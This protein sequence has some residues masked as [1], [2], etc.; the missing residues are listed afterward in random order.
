VVLRFQHHMSRL[1]S[2]L[3]LLLCAGTAWA[4]D[5]EKPRALE[6]KPTSDQIEFF[7]KKIRPA[8]VEHCYK[9]HSESAEKIKGGL[10]L[11]TR[12]GIRRGGDS[13]PAIVPGNLEESV[14]IQ[15]IRYRDKDFAMPPEK[16]GGKLPTEVIGDFEKWVQMGAPDPRDGAA[17]VVK[18]TDYE[19]AKKWWAFQPPKRAVPPAAKDAAWPRSDIDRFILAALE[20]KGLK[21][22]GDADK[23]TLLRR[24][25]FDLVGLPPSPEE[26]AAFVKDSSPGAL[27]KV[28]DSLLASSHFGE[29]WGR[30]WLDVARYAESAG[31][32]VNVAYPHAWRY[33]DYVIAAFNADKPFDQ[34]L[35]EQIAGDLLAEGDDRRRAE[36]LIA[37]GFLAIGPKSLNEQNPRQFALDVADEQIDA[38]SQAFLGMTVACARCHDHKFDP[39]S[40]REYTAL[41]GIFL[42]TDTRY[43]TPAGIQNRHPSEL[44]EL[45]TGGGAPTIPRSMSPGM[46]ERLENEAAELRKSRDA[47]IAERFGRR[48]AGENRGLRQLGEINRLGML[49]SQL[50]TFD[51]SGEPRALAMGAQDLP[52]QRAERG[53]GF[54]RSFGGPSVR[55]RIEQRLR[56]RPPE[57]M[58]VGD[59]PFFARGDADKPG[60]RVPRGFVQVLSPAGEPPRIDRRTSGRR[61]LA[62]WLAAEGNP[63]T[64]RVFVN[65]AWHWLFGRGLVE[66]VDNFGTTGAKPSNQALLD[67]L[68]V[69]FME[70]GWSIK[71]LVREIVLSRA[72][73][74]DSRFDAGSFSADPEN[75]L[76][77]RMSPRRLDAECVRD[78]MLQAGGTLEKSPPTGS[79]IALAGDGP[80]ERRRGRGTS[81]EAIIADRS[82]VRSVYLPIA[83]NV[84][85]DALEVFDFPEPSLVAGAR[86]TTN[87]PSQA[88]FLLNNPFV[89]AQAQKFAERVLA[90]YPGGP[91]GG[92]AAHL[93]QRVAYAFWLAFSRPPDP[94]EKQAAAA[95][96]A[97]FPSNWSK[98]D[99]SP[100]G[101]RD[102]GDVQ[103]AWTSFCRAL[104][105]SAEFRFLN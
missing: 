53:R 91:N 59:S 76:V 47:A 13:G 4:I 86:E 39:I 65:R 51:R 10:V 99:T 85:P 35:R 73:A 33:R 95:F 70:N 32:D 63:L 21:P 5:E 77:W 18:K 22:V 27:A 28:V 43:G 44:I 30:H 12:E 54:G 31:K 60:E 34:F 50:K 52:A 89:A 62:E 6:A 104:F 103:A 96:F 55:E 19:E 46:R 83:R 71:K 23:L 97:K 87:V 84:L 98:G 69:S 66:S 58:T 93:D 1:L 25:Y 100:S 105:A 80:I 101:I 8:L 75:A 45:P 29:R 9:C 36:M 14:L 26:A 7:E 79:V 20:E 78:A 61:E 41:A 16:D 74:L 68:A 81:E 88:L 24:V 40:Q 42:S 17:A 38:V 67:H 64:A 90:A 49:E 56:G 11:D 102:A 92:V 94:M 2:A 37:T 72:Y 48:Q 82:T 15:A 3:S 57:F